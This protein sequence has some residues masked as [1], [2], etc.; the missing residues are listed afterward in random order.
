[1]NTAPRKR[2]IWVAIGLWGLPRRGWAMF[3]LGLSVLCA[4]GFAIAGIW[5][6]RAWGGLVFALVALWYWLAIR[7]VDRNGTWRWALPIPGQQEK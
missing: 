3:F 4:L 5:H 2:P 7:W 6:T 1:M